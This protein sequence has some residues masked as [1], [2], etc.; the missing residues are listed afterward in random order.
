MVLDIGTP[1]YD[2][3]PQSAGI[4]KGYVDITFDT[5][6]AAGGEALV[7]SDIPGLACVLDGMVQI[8][9]NAKTYTAFYDSTA[10]TLWLDA[11]GAEASGDMAAVTVRMRFWG[12]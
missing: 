10:D 4:K 3:L 5:S 8:A 9:A 11:V 12:N 1:V 7:Y 2:R 6:Y